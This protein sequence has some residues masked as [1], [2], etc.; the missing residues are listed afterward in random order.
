M[1]KKIFLAALLAISGLT[2]TK[3]DDE[4]EQIAAI[5]AEMPVKTGDEAPDFTLKNLEG[6]DFS[7]SDLKG[8][9]VVLD[10]WGSWCRFCVADF[11]AM[12]EAY[13]KY[14]DRGLEVVSID[15]GE[16]EEN[17]KAAVERYKIPWINVYNPGKSKEGVSELY[18]VKAFPTKIVIDPEGKVALVFL[19]EGP[20][21]YE[22]LQQT[23]PEIEASPEVD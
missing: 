17:W 16:P 9:W 4:A 22:F 12:K 7:L 21:F 19:G 18:G 23:F 1:I 14:H 5:I 8:K 2:I 3:A 15:C 13:G 6:A 20:E 11:P 10:F